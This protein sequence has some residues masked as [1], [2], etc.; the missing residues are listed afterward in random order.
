ME[1]ARIDRETYIKLAVKEYNN[2]RP[3]ILKVNLYT[4]VQVCVKAAEAYSYQISH[5]YRGGMGSLIL[6]AISDVID[7]LLQEKKVSE[8]IHAELRHQYNRDIGGALPDVVTC[9]MQLQGVSPVRRR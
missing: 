9:L 4:I 1:V 8:E 2:L 7:R 5:L 6:A 3:V